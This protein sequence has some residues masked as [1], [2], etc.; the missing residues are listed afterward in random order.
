MSSTQAHELDFPRTAHEFDGRD[1]LEEGSRARVIPRSAGPLE[2]G[3][4]R[5]R[6]RGSA[7]SASRIRIRGC[8]WTN[9]QPGPAGVAH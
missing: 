4:S 1:A 2:A 7:G 9:E 6:G 5:R 8:L 3:C